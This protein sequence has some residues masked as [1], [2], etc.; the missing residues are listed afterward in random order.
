MNKILSVENIKKYYKSRGNTT[1]A[2]DNI[3]FE[4]ESGEYIGIMG[5]SGSGK[6]TLLNCI[7]TIDKATEGS[8]YIGN[9]EIT[10]MG[11]DE[12]SKFRREELGFIFQDFNLL[13][14]LTAHDNIALALAINGI[15]P[16]KID[17]K[18]KNIAN[19][20]GVYEILNKYPY[21]MS[22]GQKQRIACA[23]AIIT[24][25]SLILA[26]EPTGA[27]DSKSAKMF[28]ENLE[29]L[30]EELKATILMVTHDAFTASYCK[31]IL[32]I[33]DGKIFNELVRG[34]NTRQEF[35]DRIIKIISLL[36]G[37][38]KDVF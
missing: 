2:L 37:D 7:S 13:D 21:E 1:K 25:P 29:V 18:I 35:F 12:L 26:D 28:L 31:R 22:G 4:V 34:N 27:L 17:T 5:A 30:N 36:G 38:D 20:L 15:N 9:Q 14:T 23:R 10:T 3:S 8:I 11:E 24:N 33:K 19:R 32:F 6:T 16:K